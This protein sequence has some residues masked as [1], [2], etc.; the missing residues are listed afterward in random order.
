MPPPSPQAIAD[1]PTA[2]IS[3]LALWAPFVSIFVTPMPKG[4]FLF[5]LYLITTFGWASGYFISF[6]VP[7]R[8][9]GLSAVAWS[10]FWSLLWSGQTIRI[11]D[12]P[13]AK[14][15]F[16]SVRKSTSASG[17]PGGTIYYSGRLDAARECLASSHEAS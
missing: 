14:F 4:E 3:T 1:I 5:A 15:L 7:Y 10:V 16:Y 13:Q 12:M 11:H 2:F 17:R 8:Y 9:C 6:F